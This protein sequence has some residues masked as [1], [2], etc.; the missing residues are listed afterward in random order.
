MVV[1][2]SQRAQQ[3]QI[4][5]GSQETNLRRERRMEVRDVPHSKRVHHL[6]L[7]YSLQ[8][9]VFVL[10]PVLVLEPVPAP[11]YE[12]PLLTP[13]LELLVEPGPEPAWLALETVERS[14]EPSDSRAFVAD[15]IY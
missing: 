10:V 1:E 6:R 7:N 5:E 9:L 4:V 13:E 15:E 3:Q 2:S 8:Q 14:L 11:E 12:P